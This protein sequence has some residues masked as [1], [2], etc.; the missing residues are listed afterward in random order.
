[1]KYE[2]IVCTYNIKRV[3]DFTDDERK[4]VLI[5]G[6]WYQYNSDYIA[7]LQE[8]IKELDVIYDSKYDFTDNEL[9]EYVSY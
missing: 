5:K 9:K 8:S 6:E 2:Q 4:C 7:Y 1:M 3:I